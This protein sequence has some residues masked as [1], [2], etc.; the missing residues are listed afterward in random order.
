MSVLVD[1]KTRVVVQGLTGREGGFHAEQMIAYGT[2]V[3]AG[4]TPGKGGSK[5]LG[6][7]VFNTVA[8][9]ARKTGANASVAFVPPP[10]AADA[11]MEAADAGLPLVV[12]ITEG[13]PT[14]DMVRVRA[15]LDARGTRLIGPNCPGIIS[16]GQCKIGIM[17][18][19][20]HKRGPVGLV[21]R[22]GTLTYE[23]V[24]QL[25][26]RGLGQSTCIGIGGDPIIGT[27]FLDAVK[28]F[29]DD[30]DTRAIVMIGEIGGA[31]EEEAAAFIKKHVRKPVVGFIAGRTA[32]PGRRMGHAGAIIAGGKGTAAEKMAAMKKAGI[33]VVE[34]PA[35]IGETV[36]RVMKKRRR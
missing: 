4:V 32:P 25:T 28:L 12:C 21:S 7:P 19:F 15:Y 22:S 6:V 18:G 26:A 16:P 8:D 23:A 24:A 10:F 14:L 2:R 9:A 29:N 20:I 5:H 31:A 36:A 33:T 11:V 1:K 35:E 17:P 13:I 27:T 3:V 34:S 30:K